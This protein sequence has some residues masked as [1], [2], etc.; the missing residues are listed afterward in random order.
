MRIPFSI[1]FGSI[2][3]LCIGCAATPT[4]TAIPPTLSLATPTVSVSAEPT[5]TIHPTILDATLPELA[6]RQYPGS[7]I[8]Y[9]RVLAATE[10]Y[11]DSLVTYFSDG[12]KISGVLT[13]PARQG[14][15]PGVVLAHGYYD[16]GQYMSGEATEQIAHLLAENDY[17][18]F[19]PDYRG[20]GASEHGSNL[21]M[22]GYIAD[23]LNAGS[24]LK[25]LPNVD[26][27]RVGLFGHSMGAGI[28]ARAM[29]VSSV[30]QAIVLYSPI[31]A[32]NAELLM[33]PL[34]GE[35][36]GVDTDIARS[37]F[38]SMND[39]NLFYALSPK[40]Y[41]D[42][43][44]APVSIHSGTADDVT[45]TQWAEAIYRGLKKMGK[46]VEFFQYPGE[47]HVI[48]GAQQKAFDARVLSFLERNLKK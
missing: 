37:L 42:R 13:E 15:F 22:S 2:I 6:K 28:A 30:F 44:T 24:A 4:P 11:T 39:E 7:E 45:P 31:S 47:K 20:Y 33:D 40:N 3:A 14:P 35:T 18:A 48:T 9:V 29:V 32:D 12:V 36:V 27:A 21:Y 10:T 23:V 46:P 1:V 16:P 38:Q 19:A 8:K 43:V 34:G 17:V 5:P 26:A 41:Y 25:T